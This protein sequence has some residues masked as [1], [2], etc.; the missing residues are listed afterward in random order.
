[1]RLSENQ[2]IYYYNVES[3]KRTDIYNRKQLEKV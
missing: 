3:F 2:I 1:M